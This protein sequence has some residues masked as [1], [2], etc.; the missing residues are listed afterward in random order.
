MSYKNIM[1]SSSEFNGLPVWDRSFWLARAYLEAS[2][3]LCKGMV[4]DE[5]TAQYSCSRVILHL[6]RQ[7][8]ES[9]LKGA[10]FALSGQ[11]PKLTHL[12]DQLY[13]EYRR[14]CPDSSFHFEIPSWYMVDANFDL[15]PETIVGYH[16][17]LDQRYK[18]PAD[19]SGKVFAE[20]EE[21]EPS[22]AL[23]ELEA[24]WKPVLVIEHRIK[25]LKKV[26]QRP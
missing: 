8:L 26:P 19:R 23:L 9:F 5:F 16:A 10:I 25:L 17:T 4:E 1:S 7:A 24:L 22:A 11:P 3:F 14:H 13:E 2:I 6:T 21:F 12:I 18:Y 15:F 20:R